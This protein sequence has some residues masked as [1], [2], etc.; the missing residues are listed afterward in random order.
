VRRFLVRAFEAVVLAFAAYA[1]FTAPL[2]RR[3]GWGHVKAIFS[4]APAKE[5][6]DEVP[7]A[8]RRTLDRALARGRPADLELV[9]NPRDDLP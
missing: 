8:L 2:G 6:A 5:A 1:F 3:T 7:K 9:K 4:T